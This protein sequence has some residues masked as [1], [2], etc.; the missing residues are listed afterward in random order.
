MLCEEGAD[1]LDRLSQ[2]LKR[3]RHLLRSEHGGGGHGWR[4]GGGGDR[5]GDGRRA[6]RGGH[7]RLAAG[8]R[9]WAVVR[10]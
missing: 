8:G 5:P 7:R 6:G 4:P 10:T 9:G 1:D 3:R 2:V